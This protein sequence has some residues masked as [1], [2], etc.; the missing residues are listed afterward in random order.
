MTRESLTQETSP[1]KVRANTPSN[2]INTGSPTFHKSIL[3]NRVVKIPS[4]K[5]KANATADSSTIMSPI[6]STAM[7]TDEK[8]LNQLRSME[9]TIANLNK[10]IE[11]LTRQNNQ[12]NKMITSLQNQLLSNRDNE[13]KNSPQIQKNPDPS[14]EDN[15]ILSPSKRPRSSS[16]EDISHSQTS[17]THQTTN[18]IPQT[19]TGALKQTSISIETKYSKPP[20]IKVFGQPCQITVNYIKK[21]KLDS[22]F[23]TRMLSYNKHII[24]AN[25]LK[26]FNTIKSALKDNK[27]QFYTNTPKEEKEQIYLLKGLE[28]S[29]N[30]EV[31]LKDLISLKIEEISFLKVRQFKTK[32]SILENKILPIFAVHLSADS[33]AKNLE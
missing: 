5:R 23:T 8:I 15:S 7:E 25:N 26:D 1:E 16:A 18:I 30:P 33:K 11:D 17:T 12:Q 32:K 28:G 19:S 31:I 22:Y 6:K 9:K 24:N 13:N 4:R 14:M 29:F 10:V 2:L 27:I 20:S 3:S 21:L